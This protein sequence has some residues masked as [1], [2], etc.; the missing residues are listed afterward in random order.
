MGAASRSRSLAV[1]PTRILKSGER[2]TCQHNLQ[3]CAFL[4]LFEFKIHTFA[5]MKSCQVQPLPS[6]KPLTV[7][8][9]QYRWN[10]GTLLNQLSFKT[11]GLQSRISKQ[12]SGSAIL[13]RI[14]VELSLS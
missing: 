14:Y 9:G 6:A 8:R 11:F 4:I 3:Q 13:R 10:I 2:P 1:R 5:L 12:P 7:C